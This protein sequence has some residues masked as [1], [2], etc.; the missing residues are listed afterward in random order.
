MD[1]LNKSRK[2]GHQRR[3]E[4]SQLE[5][6]NAGADPKQRKLLFI[7]VKVNKNSLIISACIV[8]YSV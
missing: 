6:Q 2:S 7:P 1:K 3:L 5:L 4:K 8:L